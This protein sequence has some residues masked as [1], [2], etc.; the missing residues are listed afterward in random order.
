MPNLNFPTSTVRSAFIRYA[1][2]RSTDSTSAYEAGQITVVYNPN[3][4]IGSKWELVRNSD[5]N[6]FIDFNIIDTGQVQFSTTALA[7]INHAGKI[8]YTAVALLQSY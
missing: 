4:S 2:F 6:G 5:G 1:L 7:G 8:S 3:G